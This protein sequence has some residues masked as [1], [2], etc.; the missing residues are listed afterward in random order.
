MV[1]KFSLS[2]NDFE[3][4]TLDTFRLLQNNEEFTDVTL[5]CDGENQIKAHKVILSACSP[6]FRNILLKNPHPNPL[7]YLSGV[8]FED[9]KALVS[10]MY[11]GQTEVSQDD[12][13]SFMKAGLDLGIKGLS[14][15]LPFREDMN[16]LEYPT[17]D[18]NK[19]FKNVKEDVS[20]VN[21]QTLELYT[22]DTIIDS[23]ESEGPLPDENY[24]CENCNYASK[25]K[26]NLNKHVKSIHEGVKYPCSD[27]DYKATRT[28]NLKTH[29]L[30][31]HS[32]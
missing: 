16:T 20:S 25:Y 6:F 24:H 28:D 26:H 12:L 5:V 13:N 31:K 29:R 10:F 32:K 1:E 9:V 27:C 19:Q 22:S 3:H 18:S 11:C 8:K 23:N 7:V 15:N 14:E 21:E 4:Y 30:S 2:W 17:F